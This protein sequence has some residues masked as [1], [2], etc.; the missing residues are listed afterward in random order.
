MEQH[1]KQKTVI[2][3]LMAGIFLVL[4]GTAQAVDVKPVFMIG[5]DFGGDTMDGL[6]LANGDTV[7]VTAN[8]GFYF[9][10]GASVLNEAKTVEG[11][12]TI[13]WK[14]GAAVA[15]NQD[16]TW[17]RYPLDVLLYYR[18][19]KLR[20]GGGLTYHL[21]PELE[22][23]GDLANGTFT[24][25]DARGFVFQVDYRPAPNVGVGLRYTAIDYEFEGVEAAKGNGLG[26]TLIGRF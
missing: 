21:N 13:A 18:A 2:N 19:D 14:Q 6:I 17:T 24:F 3:V 5:Y 8:E 4:A 20:V 1:H 9:G 11:V 26:L 7:E 12:V 16:I 10:G 25:D 15:S 22:Y 23:D